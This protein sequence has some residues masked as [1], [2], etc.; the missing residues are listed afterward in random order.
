MTVWFSNS[1]RGKMFSLFQNSP[2]RFGA[3]PASKSMVIGVHFRGK[4]AT[5]WSWPLTSN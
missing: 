4:A 2:D 1:G 5:T 3:N